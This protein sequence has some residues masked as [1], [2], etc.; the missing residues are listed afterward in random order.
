MYQ[1]VKYT[2]T[3]KYCGTVYEAHDRRSTF[4]S[5]KCKD[6]DLRLRKGIKCNPNTE[7]F[8]K[9]CVNCGKPFDTFRESTVTCSHKCSVIHSKTRKRKQYEHTIAEYLQ[10]QKEKAKQNAEKKAI[11]KKWYR[12]IHTEERECKICGSLFYC[13]D[14]ETRQTCSTKCSEEYKRLKYKEHKDKRLNKHNI[15]D[16]DISLEKL[17]KRDQGVCYLCG[18]ICEW[19]DHV[20][21]DGIKICGNRYPSIDH[22]TPLARGGKH[23]WENVRLAHLKCNV[24]KSDTTPTFTKEMSREQ[25]RR[26]ASLRCTNKKQ[27]AQYTLDR[28]LIKVWES[29]GQ[30]ERELGLSSKRIQNVCRKHRSTTGNAYGFHWEYIS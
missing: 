22:V 13:L 30:I 9:V 21:R 6:I 25:A 12:L 3:C 29:T 11:E 7:P 17:Y 20:M 4:C 23:Q 28:C 16:T 19:S 2:V 18:G 27:T 24:D 26:Y 8:H 14:A 10:L 5:R 15:V 1:R